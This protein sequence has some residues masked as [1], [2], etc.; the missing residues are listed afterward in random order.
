M[1]TTIKDEKKLVKSENGYIWTAL[2]ESEMSEEEFTKN[3]NF[4]ENRVKLFEKEIENHDIETLLKEKSE[5]LDMQKKIKEEAVENFDTYWEELQKDEE[6]RITEEKTFLQQFLEN[7]DMVK[8]VELS[9]LEKTEKARA[10]ANLEQLTDAKE[11]LSE[12]NEAV[13]KGQIN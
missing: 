12:Y 11:R 6:E 3:K 13:K 8:K 10:K 5:K 1:S 9:K 7:F 2:F 4:L